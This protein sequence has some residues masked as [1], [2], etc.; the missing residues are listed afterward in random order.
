M[1]FKYSCFISYRHVQF[2]LGKKFMEQFLEGL[3]E[4]I[5]LEMGKEMEV[6]IDRER[7]NGGHLLNE[8]LSEAICQ[9]VCMIVI[10]T[11]PYFNPKDGTYCAREYLAMKKLE[12]ERLQILGSVQQGFII[13]VVIKGADSLPLEIKSRR[14]YYDFEDYFLELPEDIHK[15][16]F[17]S[18]IVKIARSVRQVYERWQLLGA[19]PCEGCEEHAIPEEEE[20]I[21]WVTQEVRPVAQSTPPLPFRKKASGE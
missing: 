15:S 9:S 14:I 17:N 11:P 10:Y 5:E 8:T 3:K 12:E 1:P 2:S 21:R 20:T 16:K 7:L 13:P 4:N 19:D 18:D 6:Y